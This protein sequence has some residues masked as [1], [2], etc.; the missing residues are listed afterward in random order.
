MSRESAPLILTLTPTL[1][2]TKKARKPRKK[3]KKDKGA[4]IIEKPLDESKPLFITIIGAAVY[5]S[6]TLKKT[7]KLF[8]SLSIRLT[9]CLI[10]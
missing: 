5:R 7:L 6:L 4:Q 10:L 9:K 8:L 2:S 1:T 3:R